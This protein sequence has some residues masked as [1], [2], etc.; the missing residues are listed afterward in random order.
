MMRAARESSASTSVQ[1]RWTVLVAGACVGLI[2]AIPPIVLSISSGVGIW[3]A[4]L[5]CI[6]LAFIVSSPSVQ[7]RLSRSQTAARF[8][9]SH[10]DFSVG[11]TTMLALE[12]VAFFLVWVGYLLAA[13]AR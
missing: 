3:S 9:R 10:R 13:L 12:A 11:L 8:P 6:A 5:D 7:R 4:A 2:A 1:R